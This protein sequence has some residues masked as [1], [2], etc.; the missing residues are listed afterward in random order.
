MIPLAEAMTSF[1]RMRHLSRP[2]LSRAAFEAAQAKALTR[3]LTRDLP[4]VAAYAGAPPRLQD[5]PVTDKAT[6]MAG[7]HRYNRPGLTAEAAWQALATG[8]MPRGLT[9]GCSTGTSGNHG[10]FVISEAERFRWLGA[11]LAKTIPDLLARPQRVA[12]VLPRDTRLY[13]SARRLPWLSLRF[14]DVTEGPEIWRA[15]LETYAPTVLLAPPRLLRHFAEEGFRLSPVRIFAAAETLDPPDRPVI[16]GHF[17][18]RLD[19]IYM[20]TEGLFA[21]TCRYGGLHLAEDS[22]VFEYEPAGNGLVAP[23]V[24]CFRRETQ[25]M[26]RYRM[27]DLLRLAD[28][29]CPCGSPLR[30]VAEIVGRMDDCFRLPGGRLITPDVLRNA[31]LNASRA[32]TD[33]RLIQLSPTEAELILPPALPDRDAEAA[34]RAVETL[35]PLR[36]TLTRAPLPLDPGRKL[37]RVECRLIRPP[38]AP[39][40]P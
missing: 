10:L 34:A 3:W 31:V 1:V 16:E 17:G 28:S 19:Q 23:L 13:H 20:A 12:V 7:F 26:A 2:G 30:H 36:L 5:L 21:V 11:I 40:G 33:F 32:I 37:R 25:I 38:P 15:E 22:V 14:F 9:V 4:R 6:L 39:P 27:N 18:L 35:L 24:T 8:A 29:P